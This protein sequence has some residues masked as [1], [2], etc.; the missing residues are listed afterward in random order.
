M[1]KSQGKLRVV[2]VPLLHK[3]EDI[4]PRFGRCPQL[5]L[6]LIE[7]KKKIRP[8]L[9]NVPY[10]P[11]TDY[12]EV[13]RG[14][15]QSS[16]DEDDG[17][18]YNRKER[19]G[20]RNKEEEEDII[21]DS[22]SDSDSGLD[23]TLKI[24]EIS[25]DDDDES[26]G[27]IRRKERRRRRERRHFN[28]DDESDVYSSS[29]RRNK[30]Y[31]PPPPSL[32]QL[33]DGDNN[34]PQNITNVVD[35]EDKK[36]ELLFKFEMLKKL[37]KGKD[38][39]EYTIHTPYDQLQKSYDHNV[40]VLSVD[41]NISNYKAYLITGFGITEQLLS[42]VFNFNA[43]GYTQQQ[44][45]MMNSYEKLLIEIGQEN[46]TPETQKWSPMVRLT[47]LILFNTATFVISKLIFSKTGTNILGMANSAMGL[48]GVQNE[49]GSPSVNTNGGGG[50]KPKRKMKG[51]SIDLNDI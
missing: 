51:P 28:D 26:G 29:S 14:N 4:Q 34:E 27:G 7:N 38:I 21:F 45:L 17:V 48:H 30:S 35:E 11:P 46:Y 33:E 6:D 32:Q 2:K 50:N 43:D 23:E 18:D 5:Y 44:I 37:Y 39:P 15:V 47:G 22:G 20:R 10:K 41:A 3:Q 19:R 40:R 36:R 1:T 24:L 12:K 9:K 42:R 49:R 13:R 8:E 31:R 16:D 25:D